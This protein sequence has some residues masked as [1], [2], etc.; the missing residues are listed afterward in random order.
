MQAQ[1]QTQTPA[2]TSNMGGGN[3]VRDRPTDSS[4]SMPSVHAMT[5]SPAQNKSQ[6]ASPQWGD[7]LG[8]RRVPSA[9]TDRGV[10]APAHAGMRT[11]RQTQTIARPSNTRGGD[12]VRDRPT[13]GGAR[14]PS[15][16]T[17]AFPAQ[18]KSRRDGALTCRSPCS[19][20]HRRLWRTCARARRHARTQAD[21]DAGGAVKQVW[22]RHPERPTQRRRLT[23]TISARDDTRSGAKEKPTRLAVMGELTRNS[24]CYRSH[25]RP[26]RNCA[27]ASRNSRTQADADAGADVKH[28]WW[29]QDEGHT[30]RRR[31]THTLNAR[32]D[33]HPG[34]KQQ[35]T[36]LAAMGG[37]SPAARR[38]PS[39]TGDRGVAA[40]NVRPTRHGAAR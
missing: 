13:Y 6:H 20:G 24:P 32:D 4:A 3:S 5:L 1:T 23:H 19:I 29:R 2:L 14:T 7:S 18:S 27:H 15:V 12:S 28:V 16:S 22:W 11:H 30:H 36:R 17:T 39:A 21:A 33:I 26:W 9:T 25:R 37:D 40:H 34:A 10:T 35:P 31:R 38:V 8:A